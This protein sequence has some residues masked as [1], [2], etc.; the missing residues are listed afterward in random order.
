V[1]DK[2]RELV[3]RIAALEQELALELHAQGERLH[4]RLAGKR[5]EFSQAVADAQRRLRMGLGAWLLRSRPRNLLS[6]PFIYGMIV[7][8]A[9]LD[10][11]VSCYQLICFPLYGIPRVR[12]GDY[13][14]I[15]RHRLPYLNAIEKLHCAYCSYANGLLAYAREITARTEQ[16]W[17]PI[18]HARPLPGQH[19]RY[20]SFLDYGD[21]ADYHARVEGL[22]QA[23]AKEATPAVAPRCEDP[24]P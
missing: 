20:P 18:K 11:C 10:A 8:L 2:V 4:Y 17:C 21:P 16:Y 7:P 6:V 3:D 22:R 23:L 13:F 12:R 5:V 24:L 1:N 9:I 14:A 19:G 15:D